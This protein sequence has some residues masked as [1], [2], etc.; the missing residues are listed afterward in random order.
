MPTASSGRILVGQSMSN[1]QLLSGFSLPK[2]VVNSVLPSVLLSTDL[3]MSY[4]LS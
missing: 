4:D 1:I 2:S 3:V